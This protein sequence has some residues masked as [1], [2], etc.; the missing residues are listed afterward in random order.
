LDRHADSPETLAQA[1]AAEDFLG[2]FQTPALTVVMTA[3]PRSVAGPRSLM[4]AANKTPPV[5]T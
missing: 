5:R 4:T 3:L 1:G 2:G